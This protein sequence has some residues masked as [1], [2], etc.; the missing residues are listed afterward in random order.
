[1]FDFIWSYAESHQAE[2]K[3]ILEDLVR[4]GPVSMGIPGLVSTGMGLN[5]LFEVVPRIVKEG[6]VG[7]LPLLPYSSMLA[8]GILY[9]TYG[10]LLN[11]QNILVVNTI[12]IILGTLYVV[13]YSSYC[14]K[15]ADWLPGRVYH[16]LVVLFL[17]CITAV[18]AA[19]FLSQS[20][21]LLL[22]GILAN[23]MSV[24][25]FGAP[26]AA[27]KTV[28]Q[29]QSTRSLPF[30]FTCAVCLNSIA[31]G[32]YGSLVLHDPLV[33][34]PNVV[35]IFFGMIQLALFARYGRDLAET[36]KKDL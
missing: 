13:I 15:G 1:M 16:H 9:F 25:T 4:F 14:P 28:V 33:V 12:S 27:I 8:G 22:L 17:M 21:A 29:E 30:G 36:D 5:P 19:I 26:L 34:F 3:W 32:T 35:G 2:L 31:W 23:I 11:N 6:T 7:K 18:G 20:N 24:T 10:W